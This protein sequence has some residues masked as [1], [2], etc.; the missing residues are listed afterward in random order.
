MTEKKRDRTLICAATVTVAFIALIVFAFVSLDN[1][2]RQLSCTVDTVE[3][4]GN[5]D[6][7]R[8]HVHTKDCGTFNYKDYV[9][10]TYSGDKGVDQIVEG[11]RYRFSLEGVNLS[12]PLIPKLSHIADFEEIDPID[13]L[14][15]PSESTLK[16]R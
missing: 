13:F 7:A 9:S 14:D 15:F 3:H 1:R 10:S 16:T 8:Y 4:V 5:E 2:T 11:K 12:I 6:S